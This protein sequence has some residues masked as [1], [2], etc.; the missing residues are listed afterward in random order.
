[1]ERDA[2]VQSAIT[3]W[4]P[5][6]V[7]NGIDV[8][9]F[10]RVTNSIERWDA[11]CQ[12]WADCGAIHEQLGADAEAS[13][14]YE[15]AGEHYFHAAMCYHFGKY[16]FV[17]DPRQ[18]RNAHE[19][20]VRDYQRALPYFLFPGERVSIPYEG[21]STMYGILRKPWHTPRPPVVI[22]VPGLD[23]VKEELHVYGE[24]FLRRGMAVLAIDGPGQGEMEFEHAMRHDY[25]VPIRYAIDYLE[26]RPD[27]DARRVG[28][29]GVSFGGHYVVRA[30]AFEKRIKATIENCGAYN[31]L[32]NFR[33]RPQLSRDTMVFRLK[34]T[35]EEEAVKRLEQFSLQG[36]A[37]CVE[38]PLLVIQG[39]QDG[40]VSP[41]HG[42][43]IAA[44]AGANAELWFFADGNHV[45]NNIPY[46]HRPQQADWMRKQLS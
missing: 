22:L 23:S 41:E 2:R 11:W 45:C 6:F 43:R 28:L 25:E 3:N 1:M 35:S 16:L 15:T 30:A 42:K 10:T 29:M 33:G 8:N 24:D 27:V 5:R 39:G 26:R 9:D 12:T 38:G 46:K 14:Y 7:A 18:L 34:A 21:G 32:E 36:V 13:G 4:A 31:Q 19:H 37:G 40:L 44:E 20:V 17:Q